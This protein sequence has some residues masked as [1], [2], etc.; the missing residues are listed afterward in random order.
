MRKLTKRELRATKQLVH[1][2]ASSG[3]SYEAACYIVGMRLKYLNAFSITN[4][5]RVFNVK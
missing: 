4:L 3:L 5:E 2:L 1:I